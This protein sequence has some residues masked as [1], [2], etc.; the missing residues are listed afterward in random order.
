ME[1]PI[2]TLLQAAVDRGVISGEQRDAMSALARELEGTAPRRGPEVARGFNAVTIAYALGAVLVIFA[3]AWFLADRWVFLGP[4]GVLGVSLVYAAI[5]AAAMRW[6]MSHGFP[7]A[8]GI[9]AMVMV[10]I[11]PVAIW[12]AE[13]V[14]G[15]WPQ[16][17]WGSAAPFDHPAYAGRWIIAELATIGLGYVMIRR[18]RF[19]AVTIPMAVALY[20]LG[21]HVALS[22]VP[23]SAP[24]FQRWVMLG[25]GLL[26]CATA[27][28]ID[29]FQ[30]PREGGGRGDLAFAFWIAGLAGVLMSVLMF[31]PTAGVLRHAVPLLAL[32]LIWASLVLGRKAHLV[33]GGLLVFLYLTY[34]ASEVFKD[35][36]IFPLVLMALGLLLIVATV[37]M[38]RRYPALV[39]RFGA[40]RRAGRAG[41]PGP[42][43]LAWLP[44]VVALGISTVKVDAVDPI[45]QR[46]LQQ[47]QR[48]PAGGGG[49]STGRPP[50]PPAQP[51]PGESPP[52]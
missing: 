49:D 10:A 47:Q 35:T 38:Q 45:R 1:H 4:W 40:R 28:T 11:T 27:D 18:T 41:L 6:L 42:L 21:V 2:S 31:W 30:R 5:A 36:A 34:L 12:A 9:A 26:L 43:W 39:E 17:S 29:R 20:T 46:R 37:W 23:G 32:A 13:A 16:L 50:A 14:T 19:V 44:T 8:A 51:N 7:E 25:D 3:C 52:G 48:A 33:A 24:V 15:L 22:I